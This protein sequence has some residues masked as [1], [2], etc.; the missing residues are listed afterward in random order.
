MAEL[1]DF[2]QEVLSIIENNLNKDKDSNLAICT[3]TN[4][5]FLLKM[6]IKGNYNDFDE[7]ISHILSALE[8]RGEIQRKR[9][10]V[11]GQG[12]IRMIILA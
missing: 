3:L 6:K 2:Q 8:K 9:K 11:P 1:T 5:E 10:Y 12:L 7:Y 4:H